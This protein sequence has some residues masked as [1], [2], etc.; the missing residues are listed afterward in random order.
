MLQ[1]LL[2]GGT[3]KYT[4]MVNTSG[5][6]TLPA[7]LREANSAL[8]RGVQGAVSA[9]IDVVNHPFPKT[10]ELLR[11]NNE[12]GAECPLPWPPSPLQSLACIIYEIAASCMHQLKELL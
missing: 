1:V 2:E 6:H 12:L 4:L 5:L 11:I 3:V 10:N 8:L 9:S 7:A